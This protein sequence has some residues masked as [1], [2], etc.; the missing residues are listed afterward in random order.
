MENDKKIPL[1]KILSS[2]DQGETSQNWNA[3]EK[4]LYLKG[5]EIFGKN[6]YKITPLYLPFASLIVGK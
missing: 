4:D 6:R 3:L 1:E 2:S 5:V